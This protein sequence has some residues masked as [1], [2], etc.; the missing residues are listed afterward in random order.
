MFENRTATE[1]KFVPDITYD[2]FQHIFSA[3]HNEW[4]CYQGRELSFLFGWIDA[5][6]IRFSARLGFPHLYSLTHFAGLFALAILLWRLLPRMLP[7]LSNTQSGLVVSLFLSSPVA[8]LSGYYYRPAKILAALMLVIVLRHALNALSRHSG[9][10]RSIHSRAHSCWKAC[11]FLR[12]CSARTGWAA[13][14]CTPTAR[15]P[16]RRT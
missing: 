10:L 9:A 11:R 1:V 8:T 3:H 12:T 14:W 6:A 15:S 7:G 16:S 13:S 5:Q 4:D 2:F